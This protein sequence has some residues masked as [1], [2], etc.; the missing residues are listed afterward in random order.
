MLCAHDQVDN[1]HLFLDFAANILLEGFFE[2]L[3][4]E[5]HLLHFDV[6]FFFL[7]GSHI[8]QTG[9]ELGGCRR[10]V[11]L[12]F[13]QDNGCSLPPCLE[14]LGCLLLFLLSVELFL[15]R[16]HLFLAFLQLHCQSLLA[17]Q[18]DLA[19]PPLLP[20]RVVRRTALIA[21]E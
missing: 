3:L 8:A 14:E 9:L 19:L 20:G 2:L 11:L 15:Q 10:R 13:L 5:F 7:N 16:G 4:H 12:Y 17:Q 21:R 1:A 18:L 6:D